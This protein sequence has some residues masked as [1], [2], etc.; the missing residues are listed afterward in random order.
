[1]KVT[2]KTN[3]G[4][5]VTLNVSSGFKLLVDDEVLLEHGGGHKCCG[6]RSCKAPYSDGSD[7]SS[8]FKEKPDYIHCKAMNSSFIDSFQWWKYEEAIGENALEIYFQSG[9]YVSYVD[10][11]TGVVLAFRDAVNRGESAGKFYNANI[12][13]VYEVFHHSEEE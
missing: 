9:N 5:E 13:N 2:I 1:M 4:A 3:E 8:L 10:V 6:G 12:K 11:P 7:S